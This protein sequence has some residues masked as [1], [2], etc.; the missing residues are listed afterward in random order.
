MANRVS[1][2]AIELITNVGVG[3]SILQVSQSVVELITGVGVQCNNP[4]NG[5]VGVPYTHTFTGG[6]G[7]P[8]VTFS[9]TSGALPPG[10]MLNSV[11]GDVTGTPTTTGTYLFTVTATDTGGL[12]GSTDCSIQIL[13]AIA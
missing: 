12:T 8:P 9:I 4:P 2:S 7:F 1:Q 10:L 13:A 11:T 6:G 5:R 3:E